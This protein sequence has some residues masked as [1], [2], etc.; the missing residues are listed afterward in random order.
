MPTG[1]ITDL[2][3]W[4]QNGEDATLFNALEDAISLVISVDLSNDLI[5]DLSTQYQVDFQLIDALTNSVVVNA[6]ETYQVPESWPYWWFSAGNNWAPPYTTAERWGLTWF[7][8][9]SVY[10]FRA[11]LTASILKGE[12][13]WEMLDTLDVSDVRWFQLQPEFYL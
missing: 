8:S 7:S 1:K 2:R 9:P 11:I 5:S 12:D 4:N 10:G 3:I 6:A 13:G